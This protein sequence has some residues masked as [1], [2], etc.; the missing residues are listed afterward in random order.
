MTTTSAQADPY[1]VLYG[2]SWDQYEKILEALG[3]YHLRHTYVEGALEMRGLLYGVAWEDYQAFLEA[4]GDHC[5]RH[6]Y[7]RGTLEMMS[8]RKDHDWVKRL[9][10]RMI[11]TMSLELEIPIQSIGSTTLSGGRG[12][13]GVQ[14]D[15]AYYVA[16]E[17]EVRGKTT[18]EPGKDPPPD[19]VIEVDV[20]NSSLHRLPSFALIGVPEVWRHDGKRMIFYRLDNDGNYVETDKSTSFPFLSPDDIKKFLDQH[21]SIDENSLIRSFVKW[22]VQER[23]ENSQ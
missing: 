11:E 19:L 15:E 1:I 7:D 3:E 21:T 18:F 4:M 6:T 5:P 20:T 10:G 2:I 9:I 17:L 22:A 12:E 14:P 16:H 13:R 8:P 23:D